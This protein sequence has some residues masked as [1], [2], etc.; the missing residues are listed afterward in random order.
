MGEIFIKADKIKVR[1]AVSN[2]FAERMNN[3]IIKEWVGRKQRK[4]IKKA[5]R[6]A[7]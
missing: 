6:G 4:E 5:T 2:R 3:F 7:E 1:Y